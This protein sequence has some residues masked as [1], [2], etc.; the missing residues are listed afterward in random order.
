MTGKHSGRRLTPIA[1]THLHGSVHL[2]FSP[3]QA[4]DAGLGALHWFDDRSTALK[5]SS[6]SGSDELKMDGNQLIPT[7]VITGLDKLSHLQRCPFSH[8]YASMARDAM[9]ADI[10][11]VIGYGLSDLHLNTWLGEAR[12]KNPM[13][14]LIFVDW[15]PNGFL[16]DTAFELERKPNEM[17]QKTAHAC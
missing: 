2:S 5:N 10:I 8:Y 6:Y 12:R 13:P 11:Y 16:F 17:F 14:P 4:Q 9:L 7:A 15:W 1:F 3:P